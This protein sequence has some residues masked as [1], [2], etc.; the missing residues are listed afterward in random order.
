[1]VDLMDLWGYLSAVLKAASMV[2]LKAGLSVAS[3]VVKMVAQIV[4]LTA[5][6]MVITTVEKLAGSMVVRM[7]L[8]IH[9]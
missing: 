9:Q 6:L 5:G 3:K 1:M 2:G 4:D 8:C 7:A